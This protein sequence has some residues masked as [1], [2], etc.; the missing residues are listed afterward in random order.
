MKDI[1]NVLTRL[2]ESDEDIHGKIVRFF[3]QNPNPND[4]QVHAFANELGMD[5]HEFE[6]HIYMVLTEFM[7]PVGKHKASPDNQFDLNELR[8]G[9]EVELEHT[10]SRTIAKEIAKDHLAECSTYYTRLK[11]MEQECE[12]E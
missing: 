1:D 7:K 5:E 12:S 3:T 11:R 9:V 10:D 8:M 6:R 2:Q 4:D